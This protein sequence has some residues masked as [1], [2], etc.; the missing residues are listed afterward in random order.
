MI[1]PSSSGWID[2]FFA[3]QKLQRIAI[4]DSDLMFFKK[5]R[6]TGLIYGYPISFDNISDFD[7][8][9]WTSQELT[10]VA[11]LVTLYN[12]FEF[13]TK[14]KRYQSFIEN[15]VVFY[16]MLNIESFNL[17]KKVFPESSL[18]STLENVIEQRVQTNNSLV[19]RNFS[20]ILTNAL[21]FEDVLAY[22]HFLQT[23]E[24]NSN[25]FKKLEET[26]VSVVSLGL[27]CKSK[28][29]DYDD[30]LIKLFESSVRY[31]KFSKVDIKNIESLHL[32]QI[33]SN[34]EKF[35]IIDLAVLAVWSE[36]EI[37]NFEKHFLFEI[38]KKM[39]VSEDF[40]LESISE[41]NDFLK[42]YKSKIP[43]FN[44]SNP[45]KHFYDHASEAVKV[46]ITRNKNRLLKEL[47]NN[48][49]LMILLTKSAT[50][51]LEDKEKKKVK[52]QLL[53][54]C[55]TIP[56]LAVFLLPGGTLLLP[57]LVKF[58]PKMLPSAFN[59]NLES[60]V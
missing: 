4:D 21:L 55:K 35:Y 29:S 48:T 31:T 37:G 16:K 53:E 15:V 54:I 8:S 58:I 11:L 39:Y 22:Q 45:V 59:E 14:E 42:T 60:D 57:I 43:F 19:A 41:T 51:G 44:Y 36:D 49:E 33:S 56:S 27:S 24:I 47:N 30:L 9:K 20:H 23:D 40:V 7:T 12:V 1:N 38:A 50:K 28:K 10:K 46:L 52:K 26:I 3:E 17:L 6:K 34:L 18:S 2:K 25:Y 32:E 13:Q 5:I